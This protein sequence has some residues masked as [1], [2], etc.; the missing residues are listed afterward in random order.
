[1]NTAGYED[2]RRVR[3]LRISGV[4][5]GEDGREIANANPTAL[6]L[7]TLHINSV[8][9]FSCMQL[10]SVILCLNNELHCIKEP[11]DGV[12]RPLDYLFFFLSMVAKELQAYVLEQ[13]RVVDTI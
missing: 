8:S 11:L 10:S 7:S 4:H 3:D 13:E 5:L 2:K 12:R 9:A 6:S 1:M